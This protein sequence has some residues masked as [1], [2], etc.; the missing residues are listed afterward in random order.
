MSKQYE[1]FWQPQEQQLPP[2][3]FEDSVAA[4]VA[5]TA[6]TIKNHVLTSYA[7]FAT[8]GEDIHDDKVWD[9]YVATFDKMGLQQYLEQHQQAYEARPK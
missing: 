7:Q 2:L 9:D 3:I 5:D 8:A 4:Q 1:E 6:T